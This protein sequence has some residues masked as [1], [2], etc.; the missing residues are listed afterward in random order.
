MTTCRVVFACLLTACARPSPPSPDS[1]GSSQ[2]KREDSPAPEPTPAEPEPTAPRPTLAASTL[3]ELIASIPALASFQH[4]AKLRVVQRRPWYGLRFDSARIAAPGPDDV[5]GEIHAITGRDPDTGD[6]VW[7]TIV[8]A[9]EF[10]YSSPSHWFAFTFSPACSVPAIAAGWYCLE[11]SSRSGD[12]A[13]PL[14]EWLAAHPGVEAVDWIALDTWKHLHRLEAIDWTKQP[15]ALVLR[16]RGGLSVCWFAGEARRCWRLDGVDQGELIQS[17]DGL[18]LETKVEHRK[19]RWALGSDGTWVT[20][21]VPDDP[22]D[23]GETEAPDYDI[24]DATRWQPIDVSTPERDYAELARLYPAEVIQT[25]GDGVVLG[26]YEEVGGAGVDQVT[27]ATWILTRHDPDASWIATAVPDLIVHDLITTGRSLG[28]IASWF[29]LG[30]GPSYERRELL[31]FTPRDGALEFVGQ[32]DTPVAMVVVGYT[33]NYA[34]SHEI[35][36]AGPDCLSLRAGP[37]SGEIYGQEE[38]NEGVAYPIAE[39]VRERFAVLAGSWRITPD[40]PQRGC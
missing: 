9:P 22:Y 33:A 15:R 31:M 4:P 3:T 26:R 12:R 40:G 20:Y 13:A 38:D 35:V 29:L 39:Q 8:H 17:V 18:A 7:A 21:S 1:E 27:I 24:G 16:E 30:D 5:A 2:T 6:T 14:R 37:S 23:S 36:A 25:Q 19:T 10:D 34:W 32:L 11:A 28:V